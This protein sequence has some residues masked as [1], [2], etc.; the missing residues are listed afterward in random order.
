MKIDQ[1]L[2]SPAM[3]AGVGLFETILVSRGEPVLG[4]R[5]ASRLIAAARELGFATPAEDRLM[6][7]M[8]PEEPR[9]HPTE[10]ALR[11]DWLAIGE[12]LARSESWTLSISQRPVPPLSLD[13]RRGCRVILLSPILRR[14]A[15]AWKTTSYLPCVLGLREAEQKG[16]NEAVFVDS[17][18]TL[19]EG[20]STNLFV[21]ES[22][23]SVATPPADGQILPGITRAWAIDT[24]RSMGV[25]VSERRCSHRDLLDRGG[26]VTGSLT[27]VAPVTHVDGEALAVSSTELVRALVERWSQML[28]IQ[29]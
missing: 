7:A 13:R 10:H 29:R 19:L 26:F 11:L 1:V 27:G 20:T 12:D 9:P 8:R 28:S 22:H 23:D 24:L 21:I 5:H 4:P 14:T 15:A 16:A 18:G 6:S 25:R 2:R 3:R 17:S